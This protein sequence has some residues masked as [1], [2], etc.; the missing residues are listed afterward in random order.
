M[1]RGRKSGNFRRV[2]PVVVDE[3]DLA[4]DFDDLAEEA[5]SRSLA[6]AVAKAHGVRASVSARR[7]LEILSNPDVTLGELSRAIEVD[8]SLAARVLRV[9]NSSAYGLR[10]RVRKISVAVTLL[11]LKRLNEIATAA[12][13]L[14]WFEHD[15]QRAPEIFRHSSATASLARH[16]ATRA[17]LPPEEM[18]TCGLLHDYGKLIMLQAGGESYA[19]LVG[20]GSGDDDEVCARERA[21]HGYDHA[22]LGARMLAEWNLPEP[23]PSVIS[24]HHQAARAWRVGGAVALM[25]AAL[26][27]AERLAHEF[28]RAMPIDDAWVD[29]VAR[30]ENV[31]RLGLARGDLHRFC[32]DLHLTWLESQQPVTLDEPSGGPLPASRPAGGLGRVG[33]A[34]AQVVARDWWRAKSVAVAVALVSLAVACAGA[35]ALLNGRPLDEFLRELL[36]STSHAIAAV[37][38]VGLLVAVVVTAPAALSAAKRR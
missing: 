16:I 6:A 3:I 34:V 10:V 28:D 4:Q 15:S 22:I 29:G 17:G 31:Q 2:Q 12:A 13:V 26:R 25:V 7:L 14:D 5:A 21:I 35:V 19:P 9:V 1:T 24:L 36:G 18:Y 32:L 38:L 23:L 27:L 37:A 8:S 20:S 30:D 33:E 11:G